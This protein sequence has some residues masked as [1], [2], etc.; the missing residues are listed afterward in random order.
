M[1]YTRGLT[2]NFKRASWAVVVV[3][4]TCSNILAYEDDFNEPKLQRKAGWWTAYEMWVVKD[5][6]RQKEDPACLADPA[7]ELKVSSP[8]QGKVEVYR[9]VPMPWNL[10]GEMRT[11]PAMAI[12]LLKGQPLATVTPIISTGVMAVLFIVVAVWRFQREEF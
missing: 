12:L 5:R 2:W 11:G 7:G 9:S 3:L 8:A 1:V 4:L 6:P 10:V